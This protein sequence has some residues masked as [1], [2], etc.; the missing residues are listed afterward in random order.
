MTVRKQ[1]SDHEIEL[2]SREKKLGREKWRP[3]KIKQ[4]PN[5]KC[6]KKKLI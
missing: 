1:Y 3:K 5:K 2:F 6:F 4:N